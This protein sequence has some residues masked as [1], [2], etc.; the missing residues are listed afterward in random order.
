MKAL[1]HYLTG[2]EVNP[3]KKKQAITVIAIKAIKVILALVK[4]GEMY[5]SSKVLGEYRLKQIKA[6]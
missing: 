2:R 6:A 4:K 3:L 5:D 1:Y